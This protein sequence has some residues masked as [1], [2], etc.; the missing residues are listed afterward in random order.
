MT[1]RKNL[2]VIAGPTAV[3]KTKVA[4]EVAKK[5]NCEIISADSRQFYKEISIGT[6]KPTSAE[7][8][9][10]K[11]HFVGFLSI[12]DG[13]SAGSFEKLALKKIN[14]LHK[15]NDNV[16]LTGGSGLYINAVLN[17]ID[18]FPEISVQTKVQADN[19]YN[20]NGIKGFQTFIQQS[21]PEYYLSVDLNNPMRLRRA[22]EVILETGLPYSSFLGQKKDPRPFNTKAYSLNLPRE[23]LYERINQRVDQML[24]DGLI[25]EARSVF[26][27]RE[28]QAL[29]TVGYK[30]LFTFF[31]GLT[32]KEEALNKIKQHTR[33]FAKRQVTWFKKQEKFNWID[34]SDPEATV[35]R[36]A[37]F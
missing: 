24:S 5:L 4:I 21:D 35:N 31:D 9:E 10:A 27:K 23:L 3:G 13:I 25:D 34:N 26:P 8:K 12:K 18:E 1:T 36:I 7:L 2:I 30:E 15:S 32:S 37:T 22:T 16:I 20:S 29:N 17:G 28:L 14:E 33:N 6:A 19:I 11:H